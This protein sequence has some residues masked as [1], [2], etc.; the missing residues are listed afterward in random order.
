MQKRVNRASHPHSSRTSN[1]N[2][3]RKSRLVQHFRL[4]Q[5]KEYR[6]RI[7]LTTFLQAREV[8][9]QPHRLCEMTRYS[10][11]RRVRLPSQQH[12]LPQVLLIS[13][14]L[15]STTLSRHTNTTLKTQWQNGNRCHPSLIC[16]PMA[17]LDTRRLPTQPLQ[18]VPRRPRTTLQHI[19]RIRLRMHF[20]SS[21]HCHRTSL[22]LLQ[23]QFIQRICQRAILG[24]ITTTSV[25]RL[26]RHFLSRKIVT[27]AR[28]A[29]KPSA[30]HRV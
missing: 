25:P 21:A 13:W 28:L 15:R 3:N 22:P 14:D 6:C 5:I 27:F 8:R 17:T 29:T 26:K 19:H 24:S 23:F 16:H 7:L 12:R 30:D 4:R 9:F 2:R 1:S 18:V 20:I 11:R 10:S